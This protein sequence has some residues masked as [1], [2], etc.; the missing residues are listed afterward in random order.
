MTMAIS[1]S[2]TKNTPNQSMSTSV[3]SRAGVSAGTVNRMIASGCQRSRGMK[4]P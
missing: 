4:I 2:V 1:H 3:A